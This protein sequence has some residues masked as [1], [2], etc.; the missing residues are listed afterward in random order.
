MREIK[1]IIIHCSDSNFG[2]AATI[3]NWHLQR[4]FDSIGYHYVVL[5]GIRYSG[6]DYNLQE[7]GMIER[8]RGDTKQGAHV[9]GHN[10][11]TIGICLIGK[12]AFTQKQLFVALPDLLLA[13]VQKHNVLVA[14]ILGH[15]ELDSKKT[16]PNLDMIDYRVYLTRYFAKPL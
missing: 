16:C 14:N 15:R 10:E 1:R 11:D 4:G 2:D 3:N 8:G 7:D 13:L 6:D 5:S 9:K 12:N